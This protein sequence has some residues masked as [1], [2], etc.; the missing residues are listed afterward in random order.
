[1]REKAIVVSKKGNKAEVEVIRTSACAKCKACSL[2]SEKKVIKVWVQNDV[3]A[4]VGQVVEIEIENRALISATFIMY[5]IP[6]VSFL[7]GVILGLNFA[8]TLNIAWEEPF[9][10]L[11]GLLFM[12]LAFLAIYLNNKRFEKSRMFTSRIVN[13]LDE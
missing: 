13:I 8:N 11:T 7:L 2:G 10:L 3:N 6:L 4:D 5:V 1:M 9:S 12:S